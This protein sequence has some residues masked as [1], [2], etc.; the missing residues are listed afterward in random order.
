[1]TTRFEQTPGSPADAMHQSS[2]FAAAED[3]AASGGCAMTTLYTYRSVARAFPPA[4][5]AS[6]PTPSFQEEYYKAQLAALGPEMRRVREAQ[7]YQLA[8]CDAIVSVVTALTSGGGAGGGVGGVD[9]GHAS[10]TPTSITCSTLLRLMDGV[11]CLDG[12]GTL[13]R[14]SLQ[15]ALP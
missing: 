7:Q 3:V 14:P 9:R 2:A 6:A 11:Y 8:A 4:P 5:Q 1:M 15:H 10:S 13:S 12:R